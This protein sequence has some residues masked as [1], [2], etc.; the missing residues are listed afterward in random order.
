ME[1]VTLILCPYPINE[2]DGVECP[3]E[4]HKILT[5]FYDLHGRNWWG[6]RGGRS[7]PLFE[8]W[9][10]VPSTFWKEFMEKFTYSKIKNR[11]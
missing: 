7:P 11:S 1:Y 10:T 4:V 2:I 6:G 3:T 9:G 5:G 8:R